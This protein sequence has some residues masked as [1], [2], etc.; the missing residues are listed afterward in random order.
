MGS[1]GGWPSDR[2]IY[3]FVIKR[4]GVWRDL[5]GGGNLRGG[6]GKVR[7]QSGNSG[8]CFCLFQ[9][10]SNIICIKL[11]AYFIGIESVASTYTFILFV[12][13][14]EHPLKQELEPIP[15]L[16]QQK[17]KDGAW[18]NLPNLGV[19]RRSLL[20]GLFHHSNFRR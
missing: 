7:E 16:I 1:S 6:C 12:A 17:R 9:E 4:T 3:W 18:E 11:L 15:A 10:H 8:R 2:L 14:R 13:N 5:K 20:P 19:V